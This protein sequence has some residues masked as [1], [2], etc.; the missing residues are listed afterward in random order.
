MQRTDGAGRYEVTLTKDAFAGAY[1]VQV[2]FRQI[3][4][5]KA[6]QRCLDATSPTL[7]I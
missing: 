1:Q 5:M 3:R 6:P 2:E 7:G 4:A